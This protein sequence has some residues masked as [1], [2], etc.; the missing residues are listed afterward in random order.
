M[1]LALQV[2]YRF[3]LAADRF[4]VPLVPYAK[5][6]LFEMDWLLLCAYCPQVAGGFRE[7]D[8]VHP[9]FQCAFCNA[10]NDVA[11]SHQR[12]TLT[13]AHRSSASISRHKRGRSAGVREH[14][15]RLGA[16]HG[17]V[18]ELR[19]A[20]RCVVGAE[21]E[22]LEVAI[23]PSSDQNLASADERGLRFQV[24]LISLDPVAFEHFE[25]E[26]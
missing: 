14:E 13:L 2:V 23:R 15:V 8:Q 6:G 4:H 20:R 11:L 18:E 16:G 3:E 24:P 12:R 5:A 21:R 9:R 17:N 25:W 19:I 1:P 7:L 22:T 26:P 10:V